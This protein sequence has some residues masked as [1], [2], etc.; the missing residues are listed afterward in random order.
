MKNLLLISASFIGAVLIAPAHASDTCPEPAWSGTGKVERVEVSQDNNLRVKFDWNGNS[1]VL[2]HLEGSA[3][4]AYPVSA[5]VCKSWLSPFLCI[6]AFTDLVHPCTSPF[7]CIHA[8]TDLVHPCTSLAMAAQ[9]SGKKMILKHN[10]PNCYPWTD[11]LGIFS[12]AYI[13]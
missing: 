2:C 6:H 12:T 8:F 7:L 4:G 10:Q 9:A 3:T 11:S 1:M 5:T 13:E